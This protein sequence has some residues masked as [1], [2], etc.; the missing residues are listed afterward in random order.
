MEKLFRWQDQIVA[1][2]VCLYH[3]AASK[4]GK[5]VYCGDVPSNIPP[6]KMLQTCDVS[7]LKHGKCKLSRMNKLMGH[8]EQEAII[9]N[10]PHIVRND[11]TADHA[12]AMFQVINVA[13]SQHFVWWDITR[14]VS[15]I[16]HP[17]Q[18]WK[19]HGGKDKALWKQ[20]DIST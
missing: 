16:P 17:Y 1:R 8:V 11:C 7:H 18:I 10:Q 4:F 14:H 2:E 19:R 13:C 15:T 3:H 6:F 20:Y 5:D 9:I 12:F